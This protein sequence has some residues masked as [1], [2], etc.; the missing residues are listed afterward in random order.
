MM[1]FQSELRELSAWAAPALQALASCLHDHQAEVLGFCQTLTKQIRRYLPQV[2]LWS[3]R[4]PE[5]Q[6]EAED[7]LVHLPSI[8]RATELPPCR[9]YSLQD[10]FQINRVRRAA[11]QEAA[12]RLAQWLWFEVWECP[13][14]IGRVRSDW[15]RNP[16]L[17]HRLGILNEALDAHLDG[18]YTL[19]I[20][21]LIAQAEGLIAQGMGHEGRM[22]GHQYRSYIETLVAMELDYWVNGSDVC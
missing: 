1:L 10:W 6:A 21:P 9:L 3:E 14:A 19:S 2:L 5:L 17:K 13:R 8:L 4:I 18:S 16:M 12:V 15:A 11:G 20:P 7:L 22:N